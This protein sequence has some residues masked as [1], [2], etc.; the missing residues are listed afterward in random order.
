MKI[1]NTP[2]NLFLK[3]TS[4]IILLFVFAFIFFI[5]YNRQP[6]GDDVL[7]QF[8]KGYNF[9]LDNFNGEIGEQ[10]TNFNMLL[11]NVKGIYL[12]N[13]GRIVGFTLLPMLSIFGQF[14]TSFLTS[15]SCALIIL[16]IVA[17]IFGS[18]S[19][20]LKHPL[21]LLIIF[22]I[23]I[24]YNPGI[25]YLLMWTM[26]SIYVVSL[27]LLLLYYFLFETKLKLGK[28]KIGFLKVLFLNILGVLAGFT[29]EVYSFVFLSFIGFLTIKEIIFNKRS[30]SILFNHIGLFLGTIACITAKGNFVRLANSHDSVLMTKSYISRFMSVLETNFKMFCGVEKYSF[31]IIFVLI[32][33][34]LYFYLF[35]NNFKQI[36]TT[37]VFLK[38]IALF[39]NNA[40]DICFL[41]YITLIWSVFPYMG[42]WGAMLFISW[43]LF[44]ILKNITVYLKDESRNILFKIEKSYLGNMIIGIVI[45]VLIS[46][47]YSW[48][49]YMSKTTKIRNLIIEEAIK[50]NQSSVDVPYYEDICSN[51]FTMFNYNNFLNNEGSRSHNVK[52]F[53]I[54]VNVTRDPNKQ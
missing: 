2:S 53:K 5:S 34:V 17:M 6:L 21:V 26:I 4:I 39:N 13:G 28:E 49:N 20:S 23:V 9:Y 37:S 14:F 38:V 1:F 29:H 16:L 18:I 52:Y 30:I 32:I 27:I 54:K 25:S 11:E 19:E 15:L 42:D 35:H 7:Y 45:L 3:F 43:L 22:L 31:L 40:I 46:Q 47:N 33:V 48:M 51:R 8:S 24:Y 36:K 50:K 10:I 12:N 44:I 41:L